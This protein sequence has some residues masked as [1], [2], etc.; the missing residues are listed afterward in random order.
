MRTG[1]KKTQKLKSSII[2]ILILVLIGLVG[3]CG[4]YGFKLGET[5]K[6][7]SFGETINKGLDLQGG[8]SVWEEIQGENVDEETIERTIELLSLRVNKMGVSETTVQKE[9]ANR[10]R[11]DFPGKFES[12]SLIESVTKTGELKFVD[13][14]KNTLLT[15]KDVKNASASYD[16][17]GKPVIS[18]ELTE[19]GAKK[20]AEAT[21]KFLNQK[22]AITMD[23]LEL[24]N[25]TVESVITDGKA[26][27]SGSQTLEEASRQ[28]NIIK[29]GALPVTLKTVSVKTVGA[30]LG[31]EALPKSLLAGAVGI[32]LAFLFM[33]LYYRVPGVLASIALTIFVI[34]NL[35]IFA[36]IGVTM[37]L[38]GIAGFLLSVGM[39]LDA[40]MLIFERIKEELKSGKSVKTSIDSGFH[41][42]LSSIL[43]SNI[44]TIIAGII[45]YNLGSG[46]VRG[47]ALTLIIGVLVSMFTAIT[48]T[49]TLMKLSVG[50]G[51]LSKPWMFGVKKNSETPKVKRTLKVVEKSKIWFSIATII[52]VLGIGGL[53]I[54]GINFGID[55]KGG[56]IVVINMEKDFDKAEV[57]AIISKYDTAA[58]S[59]KVNNTEL[60][61][62]SGSLTS[63]NVNSLINDLKDKYQL[64]EKSIVSQDTIGASIGSELKRKSLIALGVAVLAMLLYVG[65]RFEIH[66]GAAGIIKLALDVFFTLTVYVLFQIPVNSSFIAAILTIIGYSINDAIVIF[67]RIRENQKNMRRADIDDLVDTSVTQTLT[68]SINTGM[69]TLFT[70]IAVYVFVPSVSDF[71]FPIIL[72]IVFGCM[73]SILIASPLWVV[74]KNMATKRKV[75]R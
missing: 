53:L 74:F 35:L 25:P 32:G 24:T 2:L 71:A 34:L 7:K 46:S 36:G 29:S 51:L 39:A 18:L 47:F 54:K 52:V 17:Q 23:E 31:A 63:E 14:D 41:R 43:D 21:Q 40:N 56:S 26:V 33:I 12:Q 37:S 64:S 60:E 68:R 44:T 3:Y 38:S 65:F 45:L 13:P 9:G 48:V 16:Q 5:Y 8:I 20:F 61:I 50:A 49:R 59:N 75:I 55:F 66:F 10:I 1:V 11:I 62:K 22:I 72:G 69:T 6:I 28:A 58:L 27:I 67:D 57:D 42:A 30:T 19:E 15:G 70:I 73:S 4:A